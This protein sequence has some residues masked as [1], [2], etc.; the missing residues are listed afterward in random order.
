[1]EQTF[2]RQSKELAYRSWSDGFWQFG[3]FTKRF[4]GISNP[5]VNGAKMAPF[6]KDFYIIMN[7]VV[8]GTGG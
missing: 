3:D 5:W 8:G 2:C 4:P 7:V 1:M 6:N